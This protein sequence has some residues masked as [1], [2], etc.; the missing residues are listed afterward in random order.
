MNA[1]NTLQGLIA[2]VYKN[3]DVDD[4]H[5]EIRQ[6]ISVAFMKGNTFIV[7]TYQINI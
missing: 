6:D 3:D 7:S 4:G 2:Q 1:Q 5:V